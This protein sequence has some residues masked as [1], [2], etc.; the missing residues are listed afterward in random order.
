LQILLC[1]AVCLAL[2]GGGM[3]LFWYVH[4]Y[5]PR[6][7][8]R[9]VERLRREQA[10]G[11]PPSPRDYRCA[12]T[13]DSIGLT[14]DDLR[15]RNRQPIRML[16]AD[17]HRAVAFK[18][19]LLTVD[20]ICLFLARPDGTGVEVDEEMAGWDS[21][22]DALPNLLPG[23]KPWCQCFSAIAFP[24]FATNETEIFVRAGSGGSA[25]EF[26]SQAP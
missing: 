26:A 10:A 23:C 8:R 15:R 21:L 18:R 3:L 9:T 19:D 2:I 25:Q 16:W 11:I 12:I 14:V 24:A 7:A 6:H 20:C 5:L 22:M 17:V 1:L 13:F 4:W